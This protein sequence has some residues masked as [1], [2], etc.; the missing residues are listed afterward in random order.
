MLDLR[1]VAVS[2]DGSAL[3]LTGADGG[4]YRLPIDEALRVAVRG[5][6]SRLG[7]LQIEMESQLRPAEIQ[8]RIRAGQRA[9]D[10]AAAAGIPVER[11][12]RYEGPVLAER[13]HVATLARTTQLRRRGESSAAPLLGEVVS[14]RLAAEG[15]APESAAWDSW[16][17]EDTR[18][19]VQ[20][21]FSARGSERR[22]RWIFDPVRRTVCPADDEARV[23]SGEPR[24]TRSESA[25][26]PRRL[27]A[28]PAHEEAV[29]DVE[30]DG[31]IRQH[32][33]LDDVLDDEDAAVPVPAEMPATVHAVDPVV[34]VDSSPGTAVA[35]SVPA[36]VPAAVAAPEAPEAPGAPDVPDEPPADLDPPA[37]V[38]DAPGNA[39]APADQPPP[40]QRPAAKS[41]TR[42]GAGRKKGRAAVP[43]W[44]D[45]MFGTTRRPE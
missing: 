27:A 33:R 10:V 35:T 39:P 2:D 3:V 22:A 41:A 14:E 26:A 6:R 11:V 42:P 43:S 15:I 32:G 9:E 38:D 23:L 1:L 45:I 37:A 40:A 4:E 19:D 21:A 31:G 34:P 16:R 8:A 17:R 12:Q 5:H 36:S 44:D 24:P 7:Q 28:V 18:W 29:Y 13:E 30:A 25:A 20:V